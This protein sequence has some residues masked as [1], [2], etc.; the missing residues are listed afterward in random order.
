[1]SMEK[2]QCKQ[3][4]FF[5]NIFSRK[6]S[7]SKKHDIWQGVYKSFEDV[8]D[9]SDYDIEHVVEQTYTNQRNFYKNISENT[10]NLQVEDTNVSNLLPLLI[11]TIDKSPINIIDY[12]GAMGGS[13]ANVL[14]KINPKNLH[15][16]VIDLP[17]VIKII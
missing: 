17:K 10:F 11:S 8:P 7:K 15:W 4:S 16:Q 5:Q 2:T 9:C 1:M 3:K 6:K 14:N 12:G 13:F